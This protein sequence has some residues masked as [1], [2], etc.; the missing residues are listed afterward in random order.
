[1]VPDTETGQTLKS[2]PLYP[3]ERLRI[4]YQLINNPVHEGGAGITPKQGEWEN[5]ESIFALHDPEFN[6]AWIKKWSTS[7]MLK[8]DDLDQIRDRFGEKVELV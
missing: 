2:D 3:A 8:P 4:I 1:M 6:K 5:V 7:Y